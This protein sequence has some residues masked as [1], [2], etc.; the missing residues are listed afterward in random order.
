RAVGHL[1]KAGL[2]E[3]DK[4]AGTITLIKDPEEND[5]GED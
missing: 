4:I 1:L 2:I 5:N 3:E